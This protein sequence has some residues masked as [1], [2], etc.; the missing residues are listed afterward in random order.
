MKIR[1]QLIA[2]F[3]LLAILPLTGIVLYSYASSLRAV[4]RTAEVEAGSLTR[5][6]DGR[7][8]AIR[9]ELG[10]GLARVGSLSP[11]ELRT[12]AE[13]GREGRPAPELSRLVRGF[14]EAA[15]LLQSVEFIPAAPQPPA[16]GGPVPPEAPT[17]P[18]ATIDVS[19]ILRG[20]GEAVPSIPPVPGLS[21]EQRRKIQADVEQAIG[22]QAEARREIALAF[23]QR[24]EA[25]VRVG[26]AVVGTVKV[27]VR[28][29]EIV[30]RVLSRTQK[31]EGEVPFALD[32]AGK[33]FT[34]DDAD[35]RTITALPLDLAALAKEG[36]TKR[37]LD[38]WVVVT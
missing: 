9:Q 24:L 32:S 2:A 35:R 16:S 4:R 17:P 21:E 20:V 10:Q 3:L 37:V 27:R 6:M 26:D 22:Q 36:A 8:A 7:M 18:V 34:I 19:R 30:R 15:P 1:T 33:L 31:R 12:M 28:E 29:E 23:G 13:S 38:D 11:G 14:G 5:E 25:P